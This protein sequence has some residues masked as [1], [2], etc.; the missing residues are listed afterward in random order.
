MTLVNSGCAPQPLSKL[1]KP[2][3]TIDTKDAIG[4]C[5]AAIS[6][7]RERLWQIYI[8]DFERIVA[9]VGVG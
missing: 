5:V 8:Q 1:R 9:V 7:W 3:C 6:V 2:L 4:K